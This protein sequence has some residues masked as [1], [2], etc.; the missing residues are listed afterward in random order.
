MKPFIN[1]GTAIAVATLAIG[2]STLTIGASGKIAEAP[3]RLPG[4]NSV[5][6]GPM[7]YNDLWGVMDSQGNFVNP[8]T[9]GIYTF[10]AKPGGKI[11]K[12]NQNTDMIKIRAGVKVNSLYYAISTANEDTQAYLTTYYA[13]SWSK[14]SSE[15]IDVVNVPSDMTYDPVSG[16]VYG[17]FWNDEYQE[18][19]RFCRFDTYYGEAYQI[20]PGMDRNCF[21]IAANSK[22]EIYGI[23]GYTGWLIKVDPKTGL[24]E[25]IGKTGFSPGYINSLT[26]DDATGKLYWCA[27][28][29]GGGSYLLEVN[30]T[31]GQATELYQ[32]PDN[33]SFAGIFALP[34]KLPDAAP[35][36][37]S[38]LCIEFTEPGSL[39]GCFSCTAPTKTVNGADLQGPLTIAFTAGDIYKEISGVN[40]GA[41][42]V[43]ES[44]T[45]PAGAVSIE[46]VAA[47]DNLLG[48]VS[49]YDAWAGSDTPKA[50]SDFMLTDE[51]GIPT[52]S[53][54]AP[55][56]GAHGGFLDPGAIT[57]TITRINDKKVFD[58]ITTT[59]WQDTDYD[60]KS[61]ALSYSLTASNEAGTSPEAV[62]EKL[63]FGSGYTVPFVEGFDS[64]DD[65][66]LWTIF[67]LNGM[68]TWQYDTAKKNIFFSYNQEPE[69]PG[70]DWIISPA[71]TLEAGRSYQLTAD[72]KT[73]YKNY[74]ENFTFAL[75]RNCSPDAMSQVILDCQQFEN[76][77]GETKRASFTVA[78]SGRYYLGL[79]DTSIAHNWQL[80][81]DNIGISEVSGKLPAAV[82]NL[83]LTPAAKGENKATISFTTPTLDNS[84]DSLEGILSVNI[85]RDFSTS[86]TATL[87][88][89]TPG[90]DTEWIDATP[91]EAGEHNYRV[92]ATNDLGEGA[93]ASVQGWIG[94]DIPGAVTELTE[95]ENAD[96]SI[97]LSWNAPVVGAHGGWFGETTLTY[98]VVRSDGVVIEQGTSETGITDNPMLTHQELLYYLVTPYADNVKGQYNNTPYKTYGPAIQAPVAETFPAAEMTLYP[99]VAESDTQ[100]QLWTLETAGLEPM[101][102]DHTG[103]R[104]MAMFNSPEFFEGKTGTLSSPKISIKALEKPVVSF[105]MYH[106]DTGTP[107]S[108][109][110][111]TLLVSVN[112]GDYKP[113]SENSTW[114]RNDGTTGWVSHS[115]DI[116]SLRDCDWLQIQFKGE[117]AGESAFYIDDIRIDEMHDVNI[118]LTSVEIPSTFAAGATVPVNVTIANTGD[119]DVQSVT[120]TW[121][122]N[123]NTLGSKVIPGL[124]AGRELTQELSLSISEKGTHELVFAVEADKDENPSDNSVTRSVKITELIVP[125]PSDLDGSVAEN[126]AFSLRWS[127]PY[128]YP[129]ISDD[130]ESYKDW[131]ID[132]IGDYTMLDMDGD[133]TYQINKD[134]DDYPNASAPKAFQVCNA[135]K[136]GID[137]WDEGTPHS[138]H[139]MLMAIANINRVNDDWLILPQLNGSQQ[140]VRFFAKAFTSQDTPAERMRVLASSTDRHPASFTEL[141]S[142]DYIEVPDTWM[143]YS[144]VVPEGTRWFAINCVSDN[145]FALFID[146]ISYNDFRVKAS[147]VSGYKVYRD[148]ELV[149]TV[150]EPYWTDDHKPAGKNSYEVSAL[151]ADGSESPRSEVLIADTSGITETEQ[152]LLTATPSN[153]AIAIHA[154]GEME[155]IITDAA[156]RNVAFGSGSDTIYLPA[157]IYLI[158][159]RTQIIKLRI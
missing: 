19:D 134:L 36:S 46:S 17:F 150:A 14:R 137:I 98:R 35:A 81:V 72:V 60:G 43:S 131:A 80:T 95:K 133:V 75:G 99:W 11:T 151:Y 123:N 146:D 55:T 31:T 138:G 70:D 148:S 144:W 85:Y 6:S 112:G 119:S 142:G 82:A 90:Q 2:F 89:L 105:W 51:A 109:E 33:A 76:P 40:P 86:P 38:D 1:R 91:G 42:V 37:V 4:G 140:T 26:F 155:W 108:G 94:L 5:L 12:V 74:P 50:P 130:M 118:A 103:D 7:V 135:Q 44:V 96:G 58:N 128:T 9:A 156:G 145:A 24:Y 153:G 66:A 159:T 13:S 52:L 88:S 139:K 61:A 83:T 92:V 136:I 32:F 67:D 68:Q 3:L 125:A 18:Y 78:E 101:T 57:Y 45:F 53:W 22:G 48:Q 10:E 122:E 64:A 120:L 111:L 93:D 143:E 47:T 39:S 59:R 29:G 65:F 132:G 54:S 62:S 49:A 126:N 107:Q 97:T 15:E 113:F 149:A 154:P 63:V 87:S 116:T 100:I 79:H 27:N 158:H 115:V 77:T 157:G 106:T 28:D 117:A 73:Q 30:T 102:N 41:K 114:W 69:Y 25:Q 20:G 110:K 56:E 147:A 16:N 84:G 104:G 8:I 129:A 152:S 127:E 23:W 124:T 141:Q 71:I 21:A 34:Y 121:S